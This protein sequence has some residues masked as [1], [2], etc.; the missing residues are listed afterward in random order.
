[1]K[2][3][4]NDKNLLIASLVLKWIGPSGRDDTDL[5]KF[6]LLNKTSL[7]VFKKRVLKNALLFEQNTLRLNRKRN[8]IWVKLLNIDADNKDYYAFRDKVNSKDSQERTFEDD[9]QVYKAQT[10]K[11]SVAE[12]IA[13]DV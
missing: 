6:L 4:K 2:K 3:V 8:T 9:G 1:M 10:L 12:L 5:L 7:M 11:N 13:M